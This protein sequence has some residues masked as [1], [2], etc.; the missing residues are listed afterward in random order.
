LHY[1]PEF[2]GPPQ[3]ADFFEHAYTNSEKHREINAWWTDGQGYHSAI[4]P[5]FMVDTRKTEGGEFKL[6]FIRCA[7]MDSRVVLRKMVMTD[8][9]G[10]VIT[11][12]I[13]KTPLSIPFRQKQFPLFLGRG[14][15]I[16]VWRNYAEIIFKS[17]VSISKSPYQ[18]LIVGYYFRKDGS[19]QD[20]STT[21]K[22]KLER[23]RKIEN[24][25]NCW[26]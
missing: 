6:A 17:E 7:F 8:K 14:D 10:N 26:P 16:D 2:R 13:P 3:N 24:I 1:W 22:M 4:N 23:S 9:H 20:F 5:A 25:A 18:I 19:K 15:G 12:G 11:D 21:I